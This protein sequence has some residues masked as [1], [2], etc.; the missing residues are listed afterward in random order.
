LTGA[1]TEERG[2]GRKRGTK[3]ALP[4]AHEEFVEIV[5]G[6]IELWGERTQ[7]HGVGEIG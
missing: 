1:S 7:V 5:I 3:V 4:G 2:E 6:Q